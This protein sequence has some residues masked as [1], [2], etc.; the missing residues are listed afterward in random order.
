MEHTISSI[1]AERILRKGASN[2][3]YLNKDNILFK[4]V[5]GNMIGKRAVDTYKNGWRWMSE[6]SNESEVYRNPHSYDAN[7]EEIF[8]FNELSNSNQ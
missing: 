6:I 2:L 7:F 8:E 3:S 5:D 1:I 4:L